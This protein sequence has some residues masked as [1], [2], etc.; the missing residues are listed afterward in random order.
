MWGKATLHCGDLLWSYVL[1][2]LHALHGVLEA[3]S[4]AACL[5]L[6]HCRL[7]LLAHVSL[8]RCVPLLHHGRIHCLRV[9][10]SSVG[11]SR[12]LVLTH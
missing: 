5:L 9:S 3:H 11:G 8:L 1:H 2:V 10:K 12:G 6:E 4:H 7:L